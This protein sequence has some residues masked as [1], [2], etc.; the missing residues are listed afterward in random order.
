MGIQNP[1]HL[2]VITRRFER[3]P[4]ATFFLLAV[5]RFAE[6]PELYPQIRFSCCACVAMPFH[7]FFGLCRYCRLQASRTVRNACSPSQ[8][9]FTAKSATAS[10]RI[11]NTADRHLLGH[12]IFTDRLATCCA[13]KCCIVL[14]RSHPAVVCSTG[15]SILLYCN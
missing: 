14:R 6:P 4:A 8:N 11:W 7:V 12:Y 3:C 15:Q 13:K 10:S 9:I 5:A 1:Q 2:T